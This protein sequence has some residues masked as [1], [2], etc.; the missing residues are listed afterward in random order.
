MS[1][2]T[3]ADGTEPRREWL[4]PLLPFLLLG[5][6]VVVVFCV[7]MGVLI[8]SGVFAGP[9]GSAANNP[10][11][12]QGRQ[13]ATAQALA[14]TFAQTVE[15]AAPLATLT[16]SP[17]PLPTPDPGVVYPFDVA[18][19]SP[20]YTLYA[21]G[22]D[23]LG[24]AGQV[25]DM[26]GEPLSGLR[27]RVW[28]PGV[29]EVALSGS[30]TERGPAGWEVQIATRTQAATYTAQLLSSRDEPLSAP[31]AFQTED[32]CDANLLVI[33]FVQAHPIE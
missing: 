14:T 11:L 27:V 20:T 6:V 12:V 30:S 13:T 3:Q 31:F 15:A 22:C 8:A 10:T 28:G 17:T 18:E 29:D 23:W 4:G 19:D 32:A 5:G 25:F 9:S 16:P 21:Q 26:D 7:V 1:D 24:A 2:D 33:D